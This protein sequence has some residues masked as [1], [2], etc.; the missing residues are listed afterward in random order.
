MSHSRKLILAPV[1]VALALAGAGCGGGGGDDENTFIDGYN[2]ATEPLTKLTT[3]LGSGQPS[4]DSLTKVADGLDDVGARLGKLDAPDGAQDE[5]DRML[6]A[7]KSNSE[8]VR[9]LA[10][11]VK[12]GDVDKLTAA[13]EE[14][15]SAGTE[16]V[17]AE[18]A[19]RNAVGG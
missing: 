12:S 15:S 14:Y 17:A 13:S 9:A 4:Q 7:I 11:A 6:A 18:E 2:A 19:L 16:L 5:L 10:K 3:D 8:Q 1:V